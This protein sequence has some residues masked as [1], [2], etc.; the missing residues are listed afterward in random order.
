MCF[1]SYIFRIDVFLI[2]FH[3]STFYY[4]FLGE[5]NCTICIYPR[6]RVNVNILLVHQEL[7]L[8]GEGSGEERSTIAQAP[9]ALEER[10]T[11]GSGIMSF[12]KTV[13][14]RTRGVSVSPSTHPLGAEVAQSNAMAGPAQKATTEASLL[15]KVTSK[16]FL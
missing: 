8:R 12:L 13:R 6:L 7:R 10:G 9:T 11:G 4:G 15:S 3:N 14:D 1:H 5:F 16:L 2:Y